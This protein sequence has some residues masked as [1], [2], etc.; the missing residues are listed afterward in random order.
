VSTAPE[1]ALTGATGFIGLRLLTT[2]TASGRRVRGLFRPRRGRRPPPI[3]G[4]TWLPGDLN[5]RD[6]LV[7]LVA[8]THAVVHCAGA[9]RGAGRVDFDR[10]N[11]DGTAR[12]ADVVARHSP[13]ARFLLMSSLAARSPELSHY[14]ASKRRGEEA[15]QAILDPSAWTILRPPAVY[16]PGDRELL[17]LFRAMARGF[18]PLPGVGSGRFSMLF[19]DDLATAVEAWLETTIGAAIFEVDDGHRGGYDWNSALEIASRTLRGGRPIRRLSVPL[20]VLRAAAGVNLAAARLFGYSPMLT[21]GKIREIVHPDW[22]AN[23]GAFSDSTG[24]HPR[25]D[26]GRGLQRTFGLPAGG[27][28]DV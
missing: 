13:E 25:C 1:V 2:L 23:H 26:L 28:P 15:I 19:V 10:V 5:D 27:R 16:G 9:V 8:G 3:P 14:A 6:A 4:V 17:P 22:V 24:W 12:L 21:P 18:A 7:A 20:P 11:V